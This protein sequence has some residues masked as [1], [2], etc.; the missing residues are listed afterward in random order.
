MYQKG[1][2]VATIADV[3]DL[4]EK[5]VNAFLGLLSAG[6]NVYLIEKH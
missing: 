5:D 3:L 6:H 2:S 4:P 1:Y